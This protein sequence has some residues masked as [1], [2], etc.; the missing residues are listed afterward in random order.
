MI[1]HRHNDTFSVHLNHVNEDAA[2]AIIEALKASDSPYI[3]QHIGTLTRELSKAQNNLA[4][5]NL[6]YQVMGGTRRAPSLF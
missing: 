2:V 3:R 5:R 1:V 4:Q 6:T